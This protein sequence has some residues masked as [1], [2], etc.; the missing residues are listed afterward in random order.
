MKN[1]T[2]D[3]LSYRLG[4]GKLGGLRNKMLQTPFELLY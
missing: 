4:L 1:L 2:I 3:L